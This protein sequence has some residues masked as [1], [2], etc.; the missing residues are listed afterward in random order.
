MGNYPPYMLN[1]EILRLVASISTRLGQVLH[2]RDMSAYPRLRRN[3]R[4]ES[5]HSSLAIEANSLTLGNVRDVIAG[6]VVAGPEREILEV[7]NAYAAYDELPH[8]NPYSLKELL[9][10][11]GIMTAG[12]VQEAG[13]FRHGEEGVFAGGRCIFMAPPARLVPELMEGLFAWLGEAKKD[14]QPLLLS[15]IF[16]YEF[17]FI[18][19]FA[20]GNGRMARLWQTALLSRWQP[21]FAYLPIENQIHR[22]QAEYYEAISRSHAAGEST[23]FITF[24]LQMIDAVLEELLQKDL[25]AEQDEYVKKL[26]A[27]MEYDVSYKAKELQEKL[28]LKS[29]AGLKRNYIE[30]AMRQGLIAMTLPDKP[31]SRN[32]RY[33]RV[34]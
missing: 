18:H 22:Y 12:L 30:P 28:G 19:P 6:K 27:Q 29:T 8:L 20:D 1:N 11:H 9:R 3:N 5:I 13:K 32:Q 21:L 4:I 25:L 15:S 33:Y 31:T 34:R 26:L 16:H 17:V 7:K 14:L 2:Y 10:I 23:P 24:M